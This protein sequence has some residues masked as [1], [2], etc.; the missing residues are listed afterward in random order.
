MWHERLC[1]IANIETGIMYTNLIVYSILCTKLHCCFGN[2][3]LSFV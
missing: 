1:A 2:G 3:Q